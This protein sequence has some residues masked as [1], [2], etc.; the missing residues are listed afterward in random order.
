MNVYDFHVKTVDGSNVSLSKFQGKVLLIVN[1]ASGCGLTPQYEG[2]EKLYKLYKEQGFEILDFPCNQFLNQAPGSD[3]E[4]ANF[5]QMKFGTTFETFAK[6][7]VNG[8]E[9][10]PLYKYL[11]ENAPADN[12][13]ENLTKFQAIL[14][15][16]KQSVQGNAIKWNF[17]KFLV[18]KN[19]QIIQRFNPTVKPE[20]IA[21]AIEALLAS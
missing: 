15:R 8:K 1:T 17:T 13:D 2:L 20:Q 11:R 9:S 12:E 3:Q 4:L 7:S 18:D 6:I 21:P 5:C 14:E 19:G 10:H 16:L